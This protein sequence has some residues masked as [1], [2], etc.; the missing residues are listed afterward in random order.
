MVCFT[1]GKDQGETRARLKIRFFSHIRRIPPNHCQSRR[2]VRSQASDNRQDRRLL[3]RCCSRRG[4][5]FRL[6]GCFQIIVLNVVQ[7]LSSSTKNLR[8][9]SPISSPNHFSFSFTCSQCRHP[10]PRFVNWEIYSPSG[11][12]SESWLSAFLVTW[13]ILKTKSNSPGGVK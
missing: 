6:K 2:L 12:T 11:K 9:P 10:M 13:W 1:S 4:R 3:Q 7:L 5:H 8:G